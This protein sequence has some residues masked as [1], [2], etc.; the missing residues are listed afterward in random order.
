M[1]NRIAS[2]G[3]FINSLDYVDENAESLARKKMKSEVLKKAFAVQGVS[4]LTF[5]EYHIED[6]PPSNRIDRLC[7]NEE[8][9]RL[10][11]HFSNLT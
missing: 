10:V 4:Q 7:S 9:T 6:S 11:I 2:D 5:Q 1:A 3:K 8:S